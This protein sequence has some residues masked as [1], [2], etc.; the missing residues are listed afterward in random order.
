[1]KISKELLAAMGQQW[2]WMQGLLFKFRDDAD[3]IRALSVVNGTA[4]SVENRMLVTAILGT[5][6]WERDV[7][8][9]QA[10]WMP[11]DFDWTDPGFVGIAERGIESINIFSDSVFR[12]AITGKEKARREAEEKIIEGVLPRSFRQEIVRDWGVN[13]SAFFDDDVSLPL[14]HV[15]IESGGE[16]VVHAKISC[17]SGVI[18]IPGRDPRFCESFNA[19]NREVR[20]AFDEWLE[21]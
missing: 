3:G 6:D 16:D 17:W 19:S 2:Y 20:L 14:L 7:N 18:R 13:V 11:L 10:F 4:R 5:N 9:T 1:M 12:S 8:R 15:V 21:S